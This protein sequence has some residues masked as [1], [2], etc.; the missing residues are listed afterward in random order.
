MDLWV[1]AAAAGAGYLTKYWQNI[2][3]NGGTDGLL[4]FSFGDANLDKSESSRHPLHRLGHRK[5]VGDDVSN[6]SKK[7]SDAYLSESSCG[8]EVASTSGYDGEKLG[9]L[10]NYKDCNVLSLSHMSPEYSG[11][12]N[13][14]GDGAW[15]S[16][17]IDD[18]TGAT[19]PKSSNGERGS[20]RV[21]LRNKS[22]IRTERSYGHAIKPVNSLE[23]CLLA[24]LY[25][26]RADVEHVLTL[27]S[28]SSPSMRPLFVTDGNRIISRA[29]GDHFRAQIGVEENKLH[30]E[31]YLETNEN[32]CGFPPPPKLGSLDGAVLL[33]LGISIGIISSLIA[34]K[35]EVDKL[36]DL[37]KQTENLVQDLE[38]ELEMKD[39]VTV[40]EIA[41][42]NYGA[43]DTCDSSLFYK[44]PN[45]FSTEQNMDK[46]D[47]KN[48]YDRKAE[49]SSESISKIEAELEAE[50]E[51]LGLNMNTSNP[52]RRSID[53]AELDPNLM[54][55]FAQG[56][57]RAD[58]VGGLS[59]GQPGS[60]EEASSTSTDHH[61]ANYA[62][63]PRELSLRLHE[64]IQSRLEERVQELEVALQN[65]QRKVQIAELKHKDSWRDLSDN[66]RHSA[67]HEI[68]NSAEKC[69]TTEEP[70]VMNLSG[71][72]LHAYNE[73]YEELMKISES[74]GEDSPCLIFETFSAQS[75][76]QTQS[77]EVNGSAGNFAFSK[78][79]TA[80]GDSPCQAFETFRIQSSGQTQSELVNGSVGN[81]AFSKE[82]T[83]GD[84]SPCQV[85][86]TFRLQS[87]GQ[88]QSDGLDGSVKH[89]GSSKEETGGNDLLLFKSKASI[90]D[91][92]RISR[93]RR[94]KNSSVSGESSDDSDSEM[95][96]Q[97]IMQIVEKA[98]KGSPV[99]LNAQRWFRSIDEKAS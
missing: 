28:P 19:M 49:E 70:L 34:N 10:V 27:P 50:L 85:F 18:S 37:L 42:E 96:K 83:V 80:G 77:E 53:V 65:S 3:K 94:S 24:Q 5:K 73:A 26:D 68:T 55:D 31:A 38:E 8:T 14:N 7:V 89:F 21:P 93:V 86:E 72:A 44:A 87:P 15:I 25:K 12:E 64:V 76:S 22:F 16:H 23:S 81:L 40:K 29:S 67:I 20:F 6:D 88:T 11:N 79:E 30:K 13:E 43:Q 57:L 98:K 97:L 9:G 35:R 41:N 54:A 99:V 2:S 62:V 74:E 17:D 61:C 95:E 1:V 52:E 84:D 51:R 75:H 4:N 36:K 46:Y 32:T 66:H 56:E 60:N 91:E 39:S 92:E 33:C 58:L 78:E 45:S 90:S 48:S 82:E 47:D 63:S 59:V 69:K 71:E